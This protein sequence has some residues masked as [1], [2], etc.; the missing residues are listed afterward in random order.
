MDF[1]VAWQILRAVLAFGAMFLAVATIIAI[2]RFRGII[3]WKGTLRNEL[4]DLNKEAELASEIQQ[5]ALKVVLDHCQ[6]VWQASSPEIR[7]ILEISYYIRS[8]ASCYYP[9]VEKPELCISVGRFLNSAQEVVYRLELIL[10]RPGFQRLQRV[11]IRHIR[12]SYEW[13]DRLNKY[14]VVQYLIRYHMVIKRLF[15]LRLVIL[16]D[17][18]SWLAYFSNRLT[19]LT[20]TRCLLVDTYLFIGKIAIQAYDEENKESE[21]STGINE[22]EKTLEDLD[23]LKLSDLD[24]YDPQ[25]QE[26]R[27]RLVGFPSIFVSSLG[28]ED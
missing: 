13:Y 19:M 25:V 10:R 7:E 2:W 15:Q 26:I 20:L 4:N 28:F 21:F 27:N 12:K 16:P 1:S 11:R 3:N 17:P 23:S 5:Q 6:R 22:L 14:W 9:D 24:I 18:F 8:I